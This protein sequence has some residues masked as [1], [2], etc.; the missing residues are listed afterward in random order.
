MLLVSWITRSGLVAVLVLMGLVPAAPVQAQTPSFSD[1]LTKELAAAIPGLPGYGSSKY[2]QAQLCSSATQSGCT[3]P[4]KGS[5]S[6][7]DAVAKGMVPG[8]DGSRGVT[9]YWA[10]DPQYTPRTSDQIQRDWQ[11]KKS[12]RPCGR[13]EQDDTSGCKS[14]EAHPG[15]I[16]INFSG[17][18]YTSNAIVYFTR[19]C[20]DVWVQVSMALS[21]GPSHG[22]RNKPDVMNGMK[23]AAEG[24]VGPA[25]QALNAAVDKACGELGAANPNTTTSPTTSP[26]V[27]TSTNPQ[28]QLSA[29]LDCGNVVAVQVGTLA[30]PGPGTPCDLV[31]DGFR[32]DTSNPIV[33]TATNASGAPADFSLGGLVPGTG[34]VVSPGDFTQDPTNLDKPWNASLEF[35]ACPQT[36]SC[37]DARSGEPVITPADPTPIRLHVTQAGVGEVWSDV[38]MKP[39]GLGSSTRI[40]GCALG[41]SVALTFVSRDTDTDMVEF[42]ATFQSSITTAISYLRLEL[43]DPAGNPYPASG[44]TPWQSVPDPLNPGTADQRSARNLLHVFDPNTGQELTNPVGQV[45]FVGPVAIPAGIPTTYTLEAADPDRLLADPQAALLT[46]YIG[47]PSTASCKVTNIAPLPVTTGSTTPATAGSPGAEAR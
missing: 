12:E 26:T 34:I 9:I 35:Y 28:F 15:A 46:A 27:D 2:A 41:R 38:T 33:V 23:S 11:S 7:S 3:D 36:N 10:I 37:G 8:P 47:D 44:Y 18:P 43:A 6:P 30:N 19:P 13:A 31:I 1:L 42:Q 22:A 21:P 32:T 4:L 16:D 29:F 40:D 14:S 45:G 5:F 39:V 24:Q 20:A 25:A 17:D